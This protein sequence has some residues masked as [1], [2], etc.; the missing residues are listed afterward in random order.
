[1][2]IATRAVGRRAGW[3]AGRLAGNSQVGI[4]SEEERRAD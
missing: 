3:Q 4:R 1:M 2:E